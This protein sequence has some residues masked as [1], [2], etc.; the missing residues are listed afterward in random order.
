MQVPFLVLRRA[1]VNM[2]SDALI[3]RL[4]QH[5]P[6]QNPDAL[7]AH[8]GRVADALGLSIL[9]GCDAQL[10]EQAARAF[11]FETFGEFNAFREAHPCLTK[12]TAAQPALT[13]CEGRVELFSMT[14]V[15]LRTADRQLVALERACVPEEGVKE[16]VS[17]AVSRYGRCVKVLSG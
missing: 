4:V 17:L 11:G 10:E 2:W 5:A 16:G 8:A 12:A 1:F 3:E 15:V 9:R 14:E 13:D 6:S 7:V